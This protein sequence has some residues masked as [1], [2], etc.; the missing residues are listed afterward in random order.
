[1]PN[2]SGSAFERTPKSKFGQV[3]THPTHP[4]TMACRNCRIYIARFAK[5]DHA[6]FCPAP[7]ARGAEW[8]DVAP[9]N[10]RTSLMTRGRVRQTLVP[11]SAARGYRTLVESAECLPPGNTTTLVPIVT[12]P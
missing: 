6:P 3:E 2:A 12:R 9:R 7:V 1:M 10:C 11:G 8:S 5:S 4:H